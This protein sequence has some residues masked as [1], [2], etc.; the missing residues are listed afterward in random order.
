MARSVLM[1][2]LIN[3][4]EEFHRQGVRRVVFGSLF[5]R[6]HSGY[7]KA[8]MQPAQQAAEEKSRCESYKSF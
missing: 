8:A 7:N 5:P 3:V 1:H 2:L 4:V 6:H